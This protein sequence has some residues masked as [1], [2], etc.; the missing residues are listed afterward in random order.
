ML[1]QMNMFPNCDINIGH[2][3]A[4][5][6]KNLVYPL[7]FRIERTSKRRNGEIGNAKH[8]QRISQDSFN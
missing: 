4:K 6:R 7:V 5:T 2:L 1:I 3:S 8:L